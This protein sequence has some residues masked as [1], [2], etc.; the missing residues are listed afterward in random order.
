MSFKKIADTSFK[1][2]SNSKNGETTENW[3]SRVDVRLVTNDQDYEK[4]VS[5]PSFV[6]SRDI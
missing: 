4:L 2:M 5:K 3:S 6:F 1:L